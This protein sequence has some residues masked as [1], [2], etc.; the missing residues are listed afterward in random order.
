PY[1]L[2]VIAKVISIRD[3]FVTL[4]FVALGMQI[5]MPSVGILALAVV[6]SLFLVASRFVVVFPI[7]RALRLGHRASLLPAINLAQMSEFSMVIAAIGF[8][9]Q[10]ID[11]KTVSL[12][13]FV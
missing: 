11:Q 1:N 12:L 10:H 5:P 4:F 3:F 7:L 8:G 6:A 9:Y 2:D 13:I